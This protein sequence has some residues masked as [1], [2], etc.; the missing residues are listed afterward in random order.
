MYTASKSSPPVAAIAPP[1]HSEA[2]ASTSTTTTETLTYFN[3]DSTLSRT[4][5]MPNPSV[6]NRGLV[7]VQV[8][9]PPQSNTTRG[10][11]SYP[12]NEAA[13]PRTYYQHHQTTSQH[14]QTQLTNWS[15]IT[16]D[17]RIFLTESNV[18]TA[19]STSGKLIWIRI[20]IIWIPCTIF[21][22]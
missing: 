16:L 4:M 10:S 1:P 17:N 21:L 3:L 11:S 22:S 8:E 5:A 13:S 7:I 20:W 12:P 18:A 19:S 15:N 9:Q 14:E 6:S 2:A